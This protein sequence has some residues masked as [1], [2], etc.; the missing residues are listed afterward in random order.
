MH[1]RDKASMLFGIGI[2]VVATVFVLFIFYIIQRQAHFNEMQ[3][4]H[5]QIEGLEHQL[6][7]RQ[8]Q[9]VSFVEPGNVLELEFQ[10]EPAIEMQT[11]IQTEP[12]IEP[13][14]EAGTEPTNELQTEPEPP[15]P[16]G[17]SIWV[18]IPANIPAADIAR[19]LHRAGVV[20]DFDAFLAYLENNGFSR[21]IMAGN[22]LLPV[23]G[24]YDVLMNQIL[25]GRTR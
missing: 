2:G 23:D 10:T 4:L 24:G 9:S 12:I 25:A 13:S 19:I 21:S 7:M 17:G 3:D 5:E 22:F 18:H 8:Q 1:K 11:E 16:D 15:M 14:T 6:A 20:A